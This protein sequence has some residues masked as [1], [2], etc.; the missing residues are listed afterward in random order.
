MARLDALLSRLRAGL[1]HG[2][3]PEL[4]EAVVDAAYVPE[5]TVPTAGGF[6]A[7]AMPREQVP[8]SAVPAAGPA[9]SADVHRGYLDQAVVGY[10]VYGVAAATAFLVVQLSLSDTQA[11]LYS[12][13]LAMGIV[14]AGLLSHR[15]DRLAGMKAVHFVA[16]GLLGLAAFLIALGPVFIVTLGGA[17]AV[18]LGGGLLLGHVN[19]MMAAGGGAL[20]RVRIARS[21]LVAM[22]SSV[23]VPLVIGIGVA[24]GIGWQLA[25]VPAALLAGVA[26]AA[27]RGFVDR[28][29]SS[30][31]ERSRLPGYFWVAWLLVMLVVAIEFAAVFWSSTLVQRRTGVSL[32]EATLVISALV[33]GV[34]AGRVALSSHAVSDRDPV[35]LMRGGIVVGMVGL[36]LPWAS[37]SFELAMLGILIAGL[38]LGVLYPLAASI[39]LAFAPSHLL[40]ASG[41]LVLA[42]GLAI[43]VAPLVLGI[44][45][46]VT[47]VVSAWLLI[48]AICLVALALTVPVARGRDSRSVEAAST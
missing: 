35:W 46:D 37:T 45:A 33:G 27:T 29:V 34:I 13:A 14:L 17:A 31:V 8:S 48:P 2:E 7:P 11:G 44:V 41:L 19:Q 21:T 18:G 10:L 23:T 25:F 30:V 3:V 42:S 4:D 36:L 5:L 9:S 20:A 38:G 6:E 26:L 16:L 22:I 28:P 24:T 40:R 1:Y 15:L 47:G 12:S 43:L 32:G 39:T